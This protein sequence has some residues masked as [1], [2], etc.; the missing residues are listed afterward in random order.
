KNSA[1]NEDNETGQ[2]DQVAQLPDVARLAREDRAVEAAR[3]DHKESTREGSRELAV[4]RGREHEVECEC[5]DHRREAG[6]PEPF[7]DSEVS[8]EQDEAEDRGEDYDADR[9]H[10]E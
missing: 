5:E 10:R 2:R 1:K 9:G 8:D 4:V 7:V 3:T 6:P